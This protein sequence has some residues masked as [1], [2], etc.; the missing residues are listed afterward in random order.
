MSKKNLTVLFLL[1]SGVIAVLAYAGGKYSN[2]LSDNQI[3]FAKGN[4]S[5]D[6]G[7]KLEAQLRDAVVN[8]LTTRAQNHEKRLQA[9]AQSTGY[10][11]LTPEQT[12]FSDLLS[13]ASK[14]NNNQ[15]TAAMR[16]GLLTRLTYAVTNH[17]MRLRKL[18]SPTPPPTKVDGKCGTAAASCL[19][20]TVKWDNGKTAC[21]TTRTW[22][23]E[24]SNGWAT[25]YNCSLDNP[26]C[27]SYSCQG[28]YIWDTFTRE[29]KIAKGTDI[30]CRCRY[31]SMGMS[32]LGGGANTNGN[33]SRHADE[34][35]EK[36]YNG[37]RFGDLDT[38]RVAECQWRFD[39][40]T[41]VNNPVLK[42]ISIAC[43]G[44]SWWR[45]SH[46]S[47]GRY[48]HEDSAGQKSSGYRKP[49]TC[50]YACEK[51]ISDDYCTKKYHE[52]SCS[53]LS[54]SACKAQKGCRWENNNSQWWENNNN[55]AGGRTPRW[56]RE[57]NN[58][59]G[60]RNSW[61]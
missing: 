11:N 48:G 30:Q 60:G 56:K 51:K 26:A 29:W 5:T 13:T 34:A 41:A 39:D 44:S 45:P 55:H 4:L 61:H 22:N 52:E 49:T 14:N 25:A 43:L 1:L 8:G 16:N 32:H 50:R 19:A 12:S 18:E 31:E 36:F 24:G 7:N 33:F 42:D 53:S 46:H 2:W 37:E 40:R 57:N 59:A 20:G 6:R 21:G 47:W 58:Y 28:T 10:P 3:N 27:E 54:E 9:F 38:R 17:E 23:C 15:L 35:C